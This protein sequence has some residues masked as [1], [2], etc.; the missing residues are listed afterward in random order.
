MQPPLQTVWSGHYFDGRTTTRHPVTITLVPSGLEIQLANGDHDWWPY[1][2]VTQAQGA[3]E[4][5]PVRLERGGDLPEALVVEDPAFLASLRHFAHGSRGQFTKPQDRG[6]RFRIIFLAGAASIA[7]IAAIVAWGIPA[8]A[9]LVTPLVPISWEI[10]LGDALAPQLAP[11]DRR[12]TNTRLQDSIDALVTRLAST[13]P[14]SPYSFHTTIVDSPVFNAF[15]APGGQIVIYRRL[16]QSTK[17]PE[18]LA[19]LLAHEMEHVL[20]RHATKALIRDLSL[21]AI[22]GAV[23]GDVTGIGAFAL[24]GARTMTTL[25]YSR[26]TEAEADR[27]G[28]RLLQAARIDPAGM[29]RFF[30]TLKKHTGG[31]EIPAYL[32]TH[33]ET[34]ERLA[35][36]KALAAQLSVQPEPL[37]AGVKWDEVKRLCR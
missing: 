18:E 8:L 19:G 20:Q 34:D 30:E 12:C 7:L 36:M 28:M 4:H 21:A 24:Q 9:A 5:E 16:L 17:T 10:A 26:E 15:A 27:E 3:Y 2:E 35:D 6:S 33:P 25:H 29:V 1:S 11:A 13:R 23:F 14:V 37:L 22:V 32:S 31:A